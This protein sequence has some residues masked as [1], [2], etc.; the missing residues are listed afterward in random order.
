MTNHGYIEWF[1]EE[2]EFEDN[3]KGEKRLKPLV[4]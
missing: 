1:Q 2:H 3:S 4:P